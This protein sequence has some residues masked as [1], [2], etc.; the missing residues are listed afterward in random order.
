M[1]HNVQVEST[2]FDMDGII[3]NNYTKNY[4]YIYTTLILVTSLHY[5]PQ[6]HQHNMCSDKSSE[7]S[8]DVPGDFVWAEV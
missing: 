4:I 6:H 5:E 3:T 8:I 2:P 1:Q 7:R